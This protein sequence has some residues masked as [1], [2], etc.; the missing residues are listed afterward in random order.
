[1]S[2]FNSV[3]LMGN[4]TRDP[5]MRF[6]PSGTAMAKL[7]MAMNRKWR[8]KNEQLKEDVTF[9]EVTAFGKTADVAGK[10]LKK[11]EPVLIG[12]RLHFSSWQNDKG[13]KRSKL[14]VVA[15]DLRLIS[16]RPGGDS[17]GFGG[18][19]GG[20][21]GSPMGE[22]RAGAATAFED[23]E[24]MSDPFGDPPFEGGMPSDR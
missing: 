11:G 13:E 23:A 12:G 1:M 14:E 15:D 16:R 24:E 7:G 5:E 8:D 10:F 19:G 9:V 18:F 2:S 17:G 6:T 20:P 22:L 3:V 4:L 21:G